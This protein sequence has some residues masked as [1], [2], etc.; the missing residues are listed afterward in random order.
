M[1]QFT[2]AIIVSL[3]ATIT[4]FSQK[5]KR[6]FVPLIAEEPI[7]HVIVSGNI[8]VLL[9]EETPFKVG[10]KIPRSSVNKID[11]HLEGDRLYLTASPR[12]ANKERAIAFITV[13]DLHSLELKGGVVATSKGILE[14][15]QLK[16]VANEKAVIALQCDGPITVESPGIYNIKKENNYYSVFAGIM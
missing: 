16:L 14:S 7:R 10:V 12:L 1:K 2:I 8:D 3:L 15:H 4:G 5:T 13:H 6:S 11:V 9:M